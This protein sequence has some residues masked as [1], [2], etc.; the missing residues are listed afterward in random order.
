MFA[1]L[2]TEPGVVRIGPIVINRHLKISS[3]FHGTVLLPG[4]YQNQEVA[5]KRIVREAAENEK[6]M[7]HVLASKS[8]KTQHV[9]QSTAIVEDEYFLYLVSPLCEYNLYELVEN[10]DF[11]QREHL[12]DNR[13]MEMCQQL[14]HGLQE[15]HALDIL[16]RD[17]SPRNVLFGR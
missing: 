1:N 7:F 2:L 10:K 4:L 6:E 11:P 8:L 13:R 5:I 17:L 14:L 3:G 12:T 16:H 15:L 9:L